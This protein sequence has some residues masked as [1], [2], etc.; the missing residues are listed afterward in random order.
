MIAR[1]FVFYVIALFSFVC[2][3]KPSYS[4]NKN[5]K[6]TLKTLQKEG[7]RPIADGVDLENHFTAC[8]QFQAEAA[9]RYITE[10]AEWESSDLQV[11]ERRAWDA[12]CSN[13][14]LIEKGELTSSMDVEES[15]TTGSNGRQETHTDVISNQKMR[16][17]Y[18]STNADLQKIL[19]I[20]RKT[21]KGYKVQM[22]VVKE[23][24]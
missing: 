19:A 6:K 23:I 20:Y 13:I 22:V 18:T 5:E 8:C 9:N 1:I 24:K 12:A 3:A 21:E 16:I 15:V 17:S 4:L 2:V 11:A 10:Y 14:R 7:W